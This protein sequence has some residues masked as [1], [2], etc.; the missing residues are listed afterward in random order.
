MEAQ[1]IAVYL[2]TCPSANMIG[3]YYLP[4]PLLLHE[5]GMSD[6]GASKGLRRVSE[7]L[8]ASYNRAAEHVFVREMASHQIGEPLSP[9]DNRIKGIEKEWL[10][11]RKSPFFM[12][13]YQRYATSFSLSDPSKTGRGYEA[14]S[15]PLR[16][17]DQDQDQEQ[18]QDL[19]DQIREPEKAEAEIHSTAAALQ[20]ILRVRSQDPILRKLGWCVTTGKLSLA[21]VMGA[22]NG[23]RMV[24][25][26]PQRPLAYFVK[27]LKNEIP[28]FDDLMKQVPKLS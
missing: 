4:W 14:P 22:A 26:R 3:L 23:T 9:R 12:D 13:F 27:T 2:M 6:E 1:L 19:S 10:S 21:T 24:S 25:P 11:M 28:N 20:Q 17:Q 8:F 7:A 15:K 5:T 18:E 16:S